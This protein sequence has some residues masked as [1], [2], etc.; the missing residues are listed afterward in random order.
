M[1]EDLTQGTRIS[2][3]ATVGSACED[4]PEEPTSP[5]T[6]GAPKA[7]AMAE[8][9]DPTKQGNSPPPTEIS[10][11]APGQENLGRPIIDGHTEVAC[12]LRGDEI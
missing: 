4:D 3:N 7:P 2:S 11:P 12:S 1:R 8:R 10:P 9:G 6:P 5:V